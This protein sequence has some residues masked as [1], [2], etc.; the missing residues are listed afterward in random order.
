MK[1]LLARPEKLLRSVGK[2]RVAGTLLF[3]LLGLLVARY[4]WYLPICAPAER[5]YSAW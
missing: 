4:S 1:S 2:I 3:V 5:P